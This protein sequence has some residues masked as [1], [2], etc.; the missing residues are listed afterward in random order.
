[1][2]KNIRPKLLELRNRCYIAQEMRILFNDRY[3]NNSDKIND[4]NQDNFSNSVSWMT[5]QIDML[6]IFSRMTFAYE[7]SLLK[8]IKEL[9]RTH[10]HFKN[11]MK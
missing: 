3:M 7:N 4:K 11:E 1:M 5:E 6:K 2:R 10:P 9:E 8:Y